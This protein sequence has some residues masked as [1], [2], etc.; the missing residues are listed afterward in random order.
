M[1][2]RTGV[3]PFTIYPCCQSDQSPDHE[4]DGLDQ[5]SDHEQDGLEGNYQ[6][7][8]DDDSNDDDDDTQDESQEQA[9]NEGTDKDIPAEENH[10]G[11]GETADDSANGD[12]EESPEDNE[13][14]PGHENDNEAVD[15]SKDDDNEIGSGAQPNYPIKDTPFHTNIFQGFDTDFMTSSQPHQLFPRSK[16]S[17][18]DDEDDDDD[19]DDKDDKNEDDDDNDEEEDRD[20]DDDDEEEDDEESNNNASSNQNDSDGINSSLLSGETNIPEANETT[21]EEMT[22]P[23]HHVGPEDGDFI[24]TTELFGG[25]GQEADTA[26]GGNEEGMT[27]SEEGANE[28]EGG[29]M[30]DTTEETPIQFGGAHENAREPREEVGKEGYYY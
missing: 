29:Q 22:A 16:S 10:G 15:E 18:D 5:S 25:E 26:V 6:P 14:R 30:I 4:Q 8:P 23:A 21:Q 19:D 2:E 7:G 28:H 17:D 1:V 3:D 11:Q 12:K 9:V 20:E 27:E 24:Q 13:N